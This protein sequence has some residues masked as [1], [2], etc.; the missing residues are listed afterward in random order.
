MSLSRS[1]DLKHVTI[2]RARELGAVAVRIAPA[3]RDSAT[4]ERMRTAFAG[5]AFAS[6]SYD[7][8]YAQRAADPSTILAGARSVIC[9][10]VAYETKPPGARGPL[11][12]RV[13]N[14]AWSHDYHRRMQTLLRELAASIDAA[15]GA[16][17]TRVVCDTAPLA[18]RAFAAQA[19][20]GWIGKHT[21]VIVP[22]AG[23]FVFLGEIVTMLELQPDLPTK[24]SCGSCTRCV[25][26]CPTRALR[27]D[28]TID[29]SRCIADLNQRTD[30]IPPAMRPLIGD[31]LWGCDLCQE[32]CP[33]T[34]RAGPGGDRSFVP[35]GR[36]TAFPDLLK[37]LRLRSG[38]F[39]RWFGPTAMSWRGAAIVRRN[40]AVV[41][42]NLLD[43]AAVPTLLEALREDPHPMVR[44]HAAWSLGRIGSGPALEGLKSQ[45]R[46]ERDPS[47]VEAIAQ[48]LEP[49]RALQRS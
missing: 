5:N 4:E 26:V 2:K 22:G 30:D 44:R 46:N 21:N 6:W 8:S 12:G 33:P 25:D 9:I 1:G 48:A 45:C 29:A 3:L 19:G 41:L 10:A 31:W 7:A 16:N 17:V 39:K 36:S 20:L 23:S 32:I 38:E 27:G 11:E 24:K 49:F 47:V 35:A 14:Y 40:A 28:Y 42:G 34:M 43:R 13:S 18:E 15:A 37:V